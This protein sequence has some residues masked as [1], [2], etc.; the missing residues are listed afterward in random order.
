MVSYKK[1]GRDGL[2]FLPFCG[3]LQWLSWA[4]RQERVWGLRSCKAEEVVSGD[5][6]WM[7]LCREHTGLHGWVGLDK[8][9]CQWK[10]STEECVTFF[11]RIY[12]SVNSFPTLVSS[13]SAESKKCASLNASL[14]ANRGCPLRGR[15]ARFFWICGK[16]WGDFTAFKL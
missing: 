2:V 10:S 14:N 3:G 16:G 9:R 15:W 4:T 13:L 7:S 12:W 1:I 8:L 11:W 6:C 5:I